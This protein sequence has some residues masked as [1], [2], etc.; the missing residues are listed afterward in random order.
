[1]SKKFDSLYNEEALSAYIAEIK[2]FPL[3]DG[4][5]EFQLATSWKEKGDRRALDRIV[6]SHLRLVVK[7][8]NGYSGYGL[9]KV[10]LISEGNVGI[11]CALQHYDP[12]IGYRFSTYAAWWIKS[13][14]QDF[15]YN[16][17]S[18]VKLGASKNNRKL[19]F[20]L[21]KIKNLLGLNSLSS[22][23][24][25][26]VAKKLEVRP[27]EVMISEQRFVN[28]DF[29]ANMAMGEDGES[30]FQDFIADQKASPETLAIEKQEYEY[31]KKI[32]HDA[33]NTLSKR[34]YEVVCSHRL[35]SPTKTLQKIAE[36]MN[37]SAERIRQIDNA[38]FLKIQKY[39]RMNDRSRAA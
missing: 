23:D 7:I 1:M 16:S 15:I 33:L 24:A 38:A 10:D 25:E 27:E 20:S 37:V 4:D 17:W 35:R 3:L 28:K 6:K 29:S 39:V 13:K 32:L 5:E 36:E 8:A 18:I 26:I 30:S 11:M 22:E 19:F 21:R 2:K 9:S 14:M 34:E 31:R 12:S